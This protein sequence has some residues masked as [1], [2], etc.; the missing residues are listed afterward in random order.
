MRFTYPSVIFLCD[1][2]VFWAADLSLALQGCLVFCYTPVTFFW[3]GAS[4]K[5]ARRVFGKTDRRNFVQA[6]PRPPFLMKA[7]QGSF[8]RKPQFHTEAGPPYKNRRLISMYLLLSLSIFL[9]RLHALKDES[10]LRTSLQR[11]AA[12]LQ[13]AAVVY[14]VGARADLIYDLD[15]FVIPCSETNLSRRNSGS[16][17]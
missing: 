16:V 4:N 3:E 11:Q 15:V 12:R 9:V 5:T 13:Q 6:T 2:M 8:P 14:A 7:T 17:R 10:F 1:L